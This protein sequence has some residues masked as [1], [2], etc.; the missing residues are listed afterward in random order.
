[1]GAAEPSPGRPAGRAEHA[2]LV[3]GAWSW[4]G[5]AGGGVAS[6]RVLQGWGGWEVVSV[7]TLGILGAFRKKTNPS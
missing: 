2:A 3:N 5:G 6:S 7:L 1:M 4:G